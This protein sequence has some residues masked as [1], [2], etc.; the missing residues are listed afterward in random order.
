MKNNNDL[1]SPESKHESASR[2]GGARP[3]QPKRSHGSRGRLKRII[4][5]TIIDLLLI[6]IGLIVFALF[7]HAI[8]KQG[9]TEAIELPVATPA[10]TEQVAVVTPEPE[11]QP[12]QTDGEATQTPSPTPFVDQGMWGEKFADK[13]TDGEVISTDNTYQS[14]D[15]NVT[16]TKVEENSA[17]Y[18]IADIYVRDIDNFKTMMAQDTFGTGFTE[19]TVDMATNSNAIVAISGD[20]YGARNFGIVIRNG[21][22]YRDNIFEDVLI[23]NNDGSME[24]FSPDDFD[25]NTILQNGA[26]QGWSFGPLLMTDGQPMVKG[27]FNSN[28]NPRNPRSA[29]GYFEPGHYCFILVDGRQSGYSDG[30]TLED[31]S[32]VFYDLGCTVAYNLDGG[33]TAVMAFMDAETNIPYEGG[34]KTSDILYIAE[35]EG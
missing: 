27:T 29:V 6:G 31:L 8:P 30:L 26:W 19:K 34:R 24:T 23:M 4:L 17:T 5:F 13:F 25:I 22:L 10:Q 20:N 12:T 3:S 11:T 33:Q 1:F 7:H 14:E 18:Y 32:K 35:N 2:S 28:V 21:V 15:I 9:T 16:I